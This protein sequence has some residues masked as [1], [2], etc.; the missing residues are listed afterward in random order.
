[1]ANNLENKIDEISETAHNIDKELAL[2]KAAFIEH[3]RQDEFMHSELK[4][5]NDILDV[6]TAS[7]K[8]HMQQT[9]LLRDMVIKMDHRLSPMENK[10]ME[11]QVITKF[12]SERK[13]KITGII[14]LV[15]KIA[16]GL[17]ATI[18]IGIAIKTML[19]H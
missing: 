5:M 10:H 14:V 11:E 3:T 2:Q 6:N 8:E 17:S 15:A 7:L 4:R 19:G 12:Q 13:K 16:T 18:A 1:M 9:M